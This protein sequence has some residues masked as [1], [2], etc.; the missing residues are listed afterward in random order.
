[1]TYNFLKTLKDYEPEFENGKFENYL[2]LE[3]CLKEINR[4]VLDLAKDFFVFQSDMISAN[5]MFYF[6]NN[7]DN[8]AIISKLLTSFP[9]LFIRNDKME[10]L[11]GVLFLPPKFVDGILNKGNEDAKGYALVLPIYK[12][13]AKA[14]NHRDIPY[15]DNIYLPGATLAFSEGTS[16]VADTQVET[17]YGKINEETIKEAIG[18]FSGKGKNVKSFSSFRI[19]TKEAN[20]KAEGILNI[21]SSKDLAFNR[22]EEEFST[23]HTMI[24]PIL[25]LT[26]KYLCYYRNYIKAELTKEVT[27]PSNEL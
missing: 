5:F 14:Y 18:Y 2:V 7:D 26:S 21:D 15:K 8:K 24:Y 23:L 1:M 11:E 17:S 19:P 3:D 4:I 6:E 13:E 16:F 20:G 9:T 10:F 12:G 25:K 22:P 27:S